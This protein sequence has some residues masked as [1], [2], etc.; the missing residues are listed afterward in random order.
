MHYVLANIDGKIVTFVVFRGQLGSSP[1]SGIDN[2]SIYDII[3][4]TIGAERV[5]A[6]PVNINGQKRALY[7]DTGISKA[8][9]KSHGDD[10]DQADPAEPSMLQTTSC[11]YK[12]DYHARLLPVS[13]G[14]ER[15]KGNAKEICIVKDICS[16][17]WVLVCVCKA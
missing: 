15:V 10:Y 4:R 17:N 3:M 11:S 12:V 14:Y 8:L 13:Y 7:T 5:R 1:I 16:H 2:A 9:Y 6:T